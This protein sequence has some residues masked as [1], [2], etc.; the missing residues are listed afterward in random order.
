MW[1]L[2]PQSR[3]SLVCDPK[4]R[5]FQ[6]IMFQ[7][8]YETSG[9]YINQPTRVVC[10][11]EATRCF[12]LVFGVKAR[13]IFFFR[14]SLLHLWRL[15]WNKDTNQDSRMERADGFLFLMYL[16]LKVWHKTELG[17]GFKYVVIFTPIM[18]KIPILTHIFWLG[19]NHQAENIWSW[20]CLIGWRFK[21]WDPQVPRWESEESAF[22]PGG[23]SNMITCLQDGSL[24][25]YKWSYSL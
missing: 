11:C 2:L 1:C 22:G 7:D 23:R 3:E 21:T 4:E 25:S 6:T 13:V 14:E 5:C 17:S 18:G 20:P 12:R 9:M 8:Q 10:L 16:Q 24:T 19:W 15:T